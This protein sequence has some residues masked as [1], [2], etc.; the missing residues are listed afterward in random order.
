V[1]Y[2]GSA[3]VD[4]TGKAVLNKQMTAG[5]YIAF[6]QIVIGAQTI[7]SNKVTYKVP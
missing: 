7:V 4:S 1:Q 3:P 6:S 2:L 5:T